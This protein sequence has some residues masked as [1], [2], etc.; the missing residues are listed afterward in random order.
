METGRVSRQFF[1]TWS[2]L[3]EHVWQLARG[4]II[5]EQNIGHTLAFRSRQPRRQ[6]RIA[7]IS[8]DLASAAPGK[9]RNVGA[10]APAFAITAASS[11]KVQ[12]PAV[13]LHFGIRLF[14]QRL[15][16]QHPPHSLRPR[17]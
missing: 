3:R 7:F 8:A 13:S 11:R 9:Y 12:V 6:Q 16:H 10:P 17:A 4:F 14:P 15:W 1:P 5:T 2:M